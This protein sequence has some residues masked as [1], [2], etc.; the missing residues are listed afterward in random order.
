MKLLVINNLASGYQDGS[1]FDFARLCSQDGDEV[2]IRSTDG[3][4]DVASLLDNAAAFDAV[5]VAGGD[6]T[7]ATATYQ[8]A[9]TGIPILP[10]PAGTANLLANNLYAPIE[11]HALAKMV[12]NPRVL[13]FDLGEI[14]AGGRRFGFTIMAGA[15]Y[16]ATIMHAAIPGKKRFGPMAYFQAALA[17]PK[18]Q[19]S[20]ITLDID[21][22]TYRSEGLGVL[23]INFSKI[24]FDITVVHENAPRDGKL[25]IVVLKA[26]NAFELIPALVAGIRDVDGSHPD[27]TEALEEFR[28]RNV[29]VVADPPFQV[30]FDGEV[31]GL[32]TP[33]EA[34]VLPNATRFIM[35][36]TG[37]AAYSKP[38][39]DA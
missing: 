15:G 19:V 32:S 2:C 30:Q 36:D 5:V 24:Q 9:D 25:D 27:R 38:Q 29:R 14:S 33:I 20:K 23:F 8:L 26:E 16:D 37:Y 1:V 12:R 28:G 39:P 21:G 11:A 17:N 6:G 7:I 22:R 31:P 10:F 18:P 4:T 13:D 3:H 35:S 34:H